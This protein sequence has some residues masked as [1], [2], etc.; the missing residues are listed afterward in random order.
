MTETRLRTRQPAMT[1]PPSSVRMATNI[2]Y[3]II[4]LALLRPIAFLAVTAVSL[5]RGNGNIMDSDLTLALALAAA[6]VVAGWFCLMLT[7]KARNGRRWAWKTLLLLLSLVAFVGALVMTA[8]AD[9]AAIGLVMMAVP[10]VLIGLLAGRRARGYYS[11]HH[12]YQE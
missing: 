11:R 8:I 6:A 12:H 9:G 1:E 7:R 3:A 2:L 5:V 4:A 10:L